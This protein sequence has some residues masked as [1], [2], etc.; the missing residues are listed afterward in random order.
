MVADMIITEQGHVETASPHQI[1]TFRRTF[2]IRPA[3]IDGGVVV[4]QRG[5]KLDY[6]QQLQKLVLLQTLVL[7]MRLLYLVLLVVL[8]MFHHKTTKVFDLLGVL[9]MPSKLLYR[10]LVLFFHL[11]VVKNQ[12]F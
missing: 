3:F 12:K 2:Q 6:F 4:R 10:L 7:D 5:L 11:F 9:L 1:N 8:D